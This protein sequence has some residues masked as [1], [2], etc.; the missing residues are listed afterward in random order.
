MKHKR[1]GA[2]GS[3]FPLFA[4][5]LFTPGFHQLV[6]SSECLRVYRFGV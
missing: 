5:L 1:L 2:S 4:G 6:F 3:A